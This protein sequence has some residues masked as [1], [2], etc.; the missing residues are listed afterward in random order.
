VLPVARQTLVL[1]VGFG[2]GIGTLRNIDIKVLFF[3]NA[4]LQAALTTKKSR[5]TLTN[6]S[7]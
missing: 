3:G 2:V 4:S 5:V 1:I 6:T 7:E